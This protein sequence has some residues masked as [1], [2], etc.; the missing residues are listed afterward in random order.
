MRLSDS[1]ET[2]A[3]VTLTMIA[4]CLCACSESG[5]PAFSTTTRIDTRGA[6]VTSYDGWPE[7]VEITDAAHIYT[8]E[9]PGPGHPVFRARDIVVRP[10]GGLFVANMGADEILAL[11]EDGTLEWRA[12]GEGDGP[13]EFHRLTRLQNW[14]GDTLLAIDVGKSTVSFW[15]RAGDFVRERSVKISPPE[16]SEN[17]LISVRASVLGLLPVS[18]EAVVLGPQR[19]YG[20]GE[21][22]LRRAEVALNVTTERGRSET[23]LSFPGPWAFE[24][25]KQQRRSAIL[26]PMSGGIDV[27]I[28]S[29]GAPYDLVWASAD[30]YRVTGL[31][32]NGDVAK[33]FRVK[34]SRPPV[35]DDVREAY[36]E[37]WPLRNQVGNVSRVPFPNR[38]PAFDDVFVSAEGEIWA[39]RYTWKETG[40]EWVRFGRSG[41]DRF[42][43]P[44][45]VAVMAA[46]DDEAFGIRYDELN[47]EHIVKFSLP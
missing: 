14:H 26:A 12:G 19:V 32:L 21:P 5:D 43:F 13:G 39:R 29:A 16:P 6:E 42:R 27:V 22:G 17:L 23:P 47:V 34:E 25:P 11:Q 30:E 35:T 2:N 15:T 40:E 7:L 37:S 10:D 8:G 3:I 46:R 24:L 18:G 4:F 33:L 38:S 28:A 20:E 41:I 1:G 31:K 45:D 36:L 9:V 44:K